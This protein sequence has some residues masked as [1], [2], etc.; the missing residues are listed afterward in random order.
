MIGSSSSRLQDFSSGFCF[1][2]TNSKQWRIGLG[3]LFDEIRDGPHAPNQRL[4]IFDTKSVRTRSARS[5]DFVRRHKWPIRDVFSAG[6][7]NLIAFFF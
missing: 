2:P 3:D 6:T 1:I 7:E 4:S 5:L